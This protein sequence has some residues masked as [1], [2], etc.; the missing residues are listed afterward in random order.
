MVIG[1]SWP[2]I[3]YGQPSSSRQRCRASRPWTSRGP[4]RPTITG[5]SVGPQRSVLGQGVGD[6]LERHVD[7]RVVGLAA[8]DQ[9]HAGLGQ[10][11]LEADRGRAPHPLVGRIAAE[12][13]EEH[14]V[15]AR[16]HQRLDDDRRGPAAEQDRQHAA[17]AQVA[18]VGLALVRLGVPAVH[19]LLELRHALRILGQLRVPG[20]GA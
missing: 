1:V 3:V 4:P 11:V 5:S 6:G 20:C 18:D 17:A 16:L 12:I 14:R 7:P 19:L 15:A 9:Q 13:G 10:L 2:K 8:Q